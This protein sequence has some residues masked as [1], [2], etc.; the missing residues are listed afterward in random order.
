[1]AKIFDKAVYLEAN[2]LNKTLKQAIIDGDLSGGGSS[3]VEL[4]QTTLSVYG[5]T[6]TGAFY[7]RAPKAITINNIKLTLFNKSGISTG[8]L[9]VDIKKNTT[10]DDVGMTSIFSA[11]PSRDFSTD[12][13]YSESSGTM[14]TSAV[15]N[16][17]WLRLDVTSIPSGW[18]GLCHVIAYV[19]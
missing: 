4:F 18:V 8:T 10:P 5:S 3:V 12:A 15:A 2:G 17:E 6:I 14:S 9:E 1:M 13:D 11:K 19:V 16:G 7:F